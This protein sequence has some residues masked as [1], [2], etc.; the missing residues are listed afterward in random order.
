[1]KKSPAAAILLL[2]ILEAG[3]I[4]VAIVLVCA[5]TVNLKFRQ[6]SIG[7]PLAALSFKVDSLLSKHFKA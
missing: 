6:C 7:M 3:L 4:G 1:V 5:P 2:D